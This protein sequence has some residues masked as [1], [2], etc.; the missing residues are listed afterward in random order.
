MGDMFG[1]TSIAV[2]CD[3]QHQT[4]VQLLQ[5]SFIICA[6]LAGFKPSC[7]VQCT[8]PCLYYDITQ[9]LCA[10]AAK[11]CGSGGAAVAYTPHGVSQAA[12]L[13]TMCNEH[14]IEMMQVQVAESSAERW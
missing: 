5:S 11:L 7:A 6:S 3:L 13:R 12:E 8:A 1:L 10:G 4:G 14:A 2:M 9:H